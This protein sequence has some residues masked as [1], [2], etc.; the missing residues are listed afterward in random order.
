MKDEVTH[1]ELLDFLQTLEGTVILSGYTNPLYEEKLKEWTRY[2]K[3][4]V[5]EKSKPRI[6]VLWI[7]KLPL[8]KTPISML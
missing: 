5:A 6:E 4:A 3:P 1:E 7:N 8:W 2:E